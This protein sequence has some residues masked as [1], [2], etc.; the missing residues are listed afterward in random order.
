MKNL[1]NICIKFN[2]VNES[3]MYALETAL[4]N[5]QETKEAAELSIKR[6][7]DLFYIV[8]DSL[9]QIEKEL[10]EL[11]GHIKVCNAVY[12]VNR[13]NELKEELEALK[14]GEGQSE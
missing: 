1:D 6:A 9:N 10:D 4:I 11:N 7:M 12:A 2:H 5:T 14:S 8:W 3:L 13:V